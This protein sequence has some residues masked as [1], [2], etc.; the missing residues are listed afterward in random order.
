MFCR[1][2]IPTQGT[3]NS[4]NGHAR[5]AQRCA[6]SA[7]R[8]REERGRE[9]R[10]IKRRRERREKGADEGRAEGEKRADDSIVQKKTKEGT[11]G[12]EKTIGNRP[13]LSIILIF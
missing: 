5:V 4:R 1:D 10:F 12:E 6:K 9:R 13:K 7:Q 8:E 2:Q 11:R 3:K